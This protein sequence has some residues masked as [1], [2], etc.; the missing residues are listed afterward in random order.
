MRKDWLVALAVLLV[1]A[2]G[3]YSV[4]MVLRPEVVPE[5]FLYGNGQVE[6]TEVRVSAEVRGRVVESTLEEG[7]TVQSGELL[8]RLDDTDLRAA[9]AEAEAEREAIEALRRTALAQIPTWM[10]HLETAQADLRR[11]EQ[12]RQTQAIAPQQVDQAAD[13]VRE[14]EGRL[15]TLQAQA[16]EAAAKGET[17]GRR[18]ETLNLELAKTQIHAPVAGTIQS[19][20]VEV[21]EL[22]IPGRM[23][24]VLVDLSRLELKVFLP[25]TEIGRIRLN[26]PVQLRV[27]A[28]PDRYFEARVARVDQRAQFTPRDVHMPEERTRLVFGVTLA[29]ANPEG[30]LKPGMPAD[31]WIRV[32]PEVPWP[33]RLPVPR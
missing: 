17:M 12:L 28:F 29:L 31:A 21:G 9:L 6:G 2:A 23:V 7:R 25:Q 19:K 22:A 4:Y 16:A 15:R 11:F 24:A 26:D 3:S 33:E 32:A 20:G 14:A 8:V 18:V 10:H 5:G 27:D 30:Y 1:L 13:R